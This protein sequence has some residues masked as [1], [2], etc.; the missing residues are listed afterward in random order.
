M[1]PKPS[2]NAMASSLPDDTQLEH[3]AERFRILSEPMRLRIL[4]G[5][6]DEERSVTDLVEIT[7]STQANISRHLQALR[8]AGIVS[9]RKKGTWVFYSIADPTVF[10]LCRCVCG[11][12]E[13][14]KPA[15]DAFQ[16]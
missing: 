15:L 6:K 1:K 3:I 7:G 2:C 10:E 8:Q 4:A 9:R 14:L 11:G 12:S 16:T 13:N 5:L